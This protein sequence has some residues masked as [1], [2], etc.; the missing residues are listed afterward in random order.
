MIVRRHDVAESHICTSRRD[1][2]WIIHACDECDYELR[3]NWRT[4]ELIV[5]N[6]KTTVNHSGSYS[7]FGY[8]DPPSSLN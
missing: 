7:P 5:N 6:A 2:D 1:G 8:Q 3:D 4:G